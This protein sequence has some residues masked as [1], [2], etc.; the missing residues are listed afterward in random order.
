MIEVVYTGH[1]NVPILV[2]DESERCSI[3][4][5]QCSHHVPLQL[6]QCQCVA[7]IEGQLAMLDVGLCCAGHLLKYWLYYRI[8]ARSLRVLQKPTQKPKAPE[9]P[10]PKPK[11]RTPKIGFG[12]LF[13]NRAEIFYRKSLCDIAVSDLQPN[14]I[15]C[16]LKLR[17]QNCISTLDL[18]C[19]TPIVLLQT[20]RSQY[21]AKA[22]ASPI[23]SLRL[24]C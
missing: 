12:R 2:V 4:E 5:S 16:R 22:V 1:V 21:S 24:R 18:P 6:S 8:D 9:P 15:V 11:F 7:Q 14:T 10:E 19:V 20:A 23:D 17:L 13:L 3:D